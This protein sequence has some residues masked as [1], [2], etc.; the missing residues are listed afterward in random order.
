[1]AKVSAKAKIN[2][3]GQ[4]VK[5]NIRLGMEQRIKLAAMMLRDQTVRNISRPVTKIKGRRRDSKGKFRSATRVD[6]TSR[7]KPG[8]FPKADT[9]RLMKDIF[10]QEDNR[11]FRGP[12]AI[13]GTTLDYGAI[14]ELSSRLDRSFLRRTHREQLGRIRQILLT[15]PPLPGQK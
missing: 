12:G 9:T 7:S 3:H 4:K 14:L 10:W 2:W 15:G 5:R 6:P 8:E 13:I 11:F 1:M